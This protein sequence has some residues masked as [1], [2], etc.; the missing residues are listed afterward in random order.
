MLVL[1]LLS[2]LS[3]YLINRH[4]IVRGRRTVSLGSKDIFQKEK[5]NGW[6]Q[7]TGTELLVVCPTI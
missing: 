4:N 6:G 7:V 2:L 3:L 5:K 1:V